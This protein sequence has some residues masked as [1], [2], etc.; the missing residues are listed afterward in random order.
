MF[1]L[2]SGMLCLVY[3]VLLENLAAGLELTIVW[4]LLALGFLCTY[5][6][7]VYRKAHPAKK[8]RPLWQKTFCYTSLA[9]F[10]VLAGVTVSRTVAGMFLPVPEELEYIAIL[11]EE[12]VEGESEQELV[13]RLNRAVAYLEE[14]PQTCVIVSGGWDSE[15][16]SS[17]AHVMYLYLLRHDIG[18]E[19][20]FWETYS[21]ST[22]DNLINSAAIAGG[23][24]SKL[25]IVVS[26]Y[27]AYRAMRIARNTGLPNV[28]AVPSATPL[29]LLPHRLAAEL[30]WVLHDKF[31]GI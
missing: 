20:I 21:R 23:R 6:L 25:G 11:S 19:R 10:L 22:K 13:D 31:L 24:W 18:N 15:K 2:L 28:C 14:N 12:E 26:D 1:W 9:L 17:R 30:L 7:K 4:L 8:K 16:G 5:L 29:W 3:Y 27:F